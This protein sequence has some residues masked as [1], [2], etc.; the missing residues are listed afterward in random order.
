MPGTVFTLPA[1]LPILVTTSPVVPSYPDTYTALVAGEYVTVQQG[2]IN[3]Q[4]AVGTQGTGSMTVKSA[5]GTVWEYGTQALIYDETGTI[6]Y[7]GFIANDHA[8]RDAGARQGDLGWLNHDL[9]LMDNTYKASKRYAFKAYANTTAGAIVLDIWGTYLA[10]EG[11]TASSATVATG[12]TIVQGVWGGSKSIAE[13]FNWLAQQA[14]FWWTIDESL[15]LWFQPYGGIPAPFSLDGTNVDAMQSVTVDS[16]NSML[17]NKQYVKGSVA[18]KGTT[19]APLVESFKGDGASRSF[20]LGYELNTLISVTLNGLDITSLVQDKG[21]SGGSYYA[22]VGDPV[23]TQDPSQSVLTSSDTLVVTYIG[24]FPVIAAAQSSAQI[25]AQAARERTGTGIIE[26]V[27]S[28]T[29][30]RSLPAAFQVASGL[31]TH[32]GADTTLLTFN[33]KETG[34]QPGQLLNVTLSDYNISNLPMLI[35]GVNISD[36]QDGLTIWF[37]VAAVGA[38]GAAAWA[39]ESS[40]W[41]TY[42]HNLMAQSS[43]P[44]DYTD[45]QDTALV[46]P[47][48]SVASHTPS[49]TITATKAIC[50]FPSDTLFPSSSLFPC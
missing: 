20:T 39:V 23:I 47:S 13:I 12:P 3:I 42:F 36:Q 17:T 24:Q 33:T 48:V 9:T 15:T 2:S 37:Q 19:T 21:S 14:G 49:V 16:G 34:L 8:Y 10:A 41:T 7:G 1:T 38:P 44:S 30:L 27:Y 28:D 46:I 5:L 22:L 43:D 31:L 40:Q 35:A 6:A 32:F 11:V 50:S 26:T 4:K 45:A 18:Q 29:K 25:S